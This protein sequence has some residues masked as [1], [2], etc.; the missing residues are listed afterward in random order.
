MKFE[1]MKK[2][3]FI[4]VAIIP[5]WAFSQTEYQFSAHR[6]EVANGYNFWLCIPDTYEAQKEK[7]PLILFLH[8]HSLSGTDLNRV[9][10]YG[11]LDAISMGKDINA[12]VVAPQDPG[13][14][15]NAQK[16]NNIL[17]WVQA[18]MAFDTNRIYVI[19]M[20]MGGYGTFQYVGTY[21]DRVAAAMAFCGGS[22]LRD[23]CGLNTVPLWII[24][25]T[26]DRAVTVSES[27]KVVNAMKSCG[28]T[29]LLRFDKLS[30]VNHSQMAKMF[31]IPETYEWLFRHSKADSVRKVDKEVVITASTMGAAYQ[32]IDRTANKIVVVDPNKAIPLDTNQALTTDTAVKAQVEST[33]AK[34]TTT[35]HKNSPKYHIVKKGDTLYAIARKY[36][37][38]VDKLCK[39]NR[40]KETS[41]LSLG[42]KI[43]VK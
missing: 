22:N 14:P 36:H 4:I 42:Q 11:C 26:A 17:D 7:M 38:T 33:P 6:N 23:H 10:K 37:T 32:N 5:L 1:I 25:G 8:G 16:L 13:G 34:Q 43:K 41:I 21:P 9:R 35:P 18:R 20:S 27:Q 12:I 31:Y 29:D 2:I 3:L 40:I 30:G 19:G 28:K 15:W 39:L 24:H